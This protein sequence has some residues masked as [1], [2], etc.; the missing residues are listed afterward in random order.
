[1][2]ELE[3]PGRAAKGLA[4]LPPHYEKADARYGKAD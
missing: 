2:L 3:S 1:M 4:K